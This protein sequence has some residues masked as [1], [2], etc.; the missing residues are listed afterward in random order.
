V[1]ERLART[2]AAYPR[3]TLALWG[4]A[5]VVR[6]RGC[7]APRRDRDPLGRPARDV[8]LLDGRAWYLSR[9]LDWLPHADIE[10]APAPPVAS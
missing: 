5:V 4:L 2:C 10:G 9:W 6:R 1:T 7:A 8:G 3:R